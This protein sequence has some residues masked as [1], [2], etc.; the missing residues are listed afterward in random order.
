MKIFE[1]EFLTW[2]QL[3]EEAHKG[4]LFILSVAPLEDHASHLPSGTDPII[5]QAL[6]YRVAELLEPIPGLTPDGSEINVVMLPAWYQGASALR[7]LGCLRWL[8]STLTKA[9]V[10]YGTELAEIGVRRL[11]LLS[12]HGA[13]SHMSALDKAAAW[14]QKNTRLRVLSPSGAMLEGFLTGNY[15]EPVQ[16]YLGRAYTEPEREG[17]RGDVHGAGWETSILL[18]LQPDLVDPAYRY[19]PAH[20]VPRGTRQRLRALRAHRGYFGT[21]AVASVE[22]GEAAFEVLCR[23]AVAVVQ[24]FCA[25]PVRHHR[26]VAAVPR[27]PAKRGEQVGKLLVGLAAGALLF[28]FWDRPRPV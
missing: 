13:D 5:C 25:L 22:L 28:W 23:Q 4:S 15:D 11:V 17:L 6:A 20:P 27:R 24:E 21:P 26:R 14:L 12:S 8:K 19:L 16:E 18:Y 3:R 2:D 9:L 1:A 7:S 10:E